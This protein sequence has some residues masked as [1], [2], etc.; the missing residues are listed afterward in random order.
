MLALRNFV[1][2]ENKKGF[3]STTMLVALD[4]FL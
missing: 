2:P 3:F 1:K 4:A